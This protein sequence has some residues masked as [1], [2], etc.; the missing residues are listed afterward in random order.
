MTKPITLLLALLVAAVAAMGQVPVITSVSPSSGSVGSSVTIS[1]SNFNSSVSGNVVS[2]GG[3]HAAVTSAGTSQLV[4]TVPNGA[5]YA[6]VSVTN[7]ATR[8]TAY[9]SQPFTTTFSQGNTIGPSA[10][11][12]NVDFGTGNNP[13][14]VA[15]ADIDG[16]GK[17]DIVA[18]NATSN[19]V[20]VL[21]NNS[22]GSS[23]GSASFKGKMD[24]SVDA[25]P[26][27]IS[28]GDVDGDGR[29]DVVVAYQLGKQVSV[30]LNNSSPGAVSFLA[31]TDFSCR[32]NSSAVAIG[33]IDR[34]GKPD[35]VVA[36]FLNNNVSVLKNSTAGGGLSFAGPVDFV[37]GN[38]PGSLCISDLDG[39]GK[40]DLVVG[41]YASNT[42]S[43]LQN[44]SAN[45]T[46]D[47]STFGG[48]VDLPLGGAPT[49]LFAGD[50]DGDGKPDIVVSNYNASRN[51]VTIL[52]NN[53]S[54][55]G[56]LGSTSFASGVDFTTGNQPV[57]VGMADLDGDGKVDMVT[58]DYNSNSVTVL[59]NTSS[60]SISVSS[61]VSKTDFT[62]GNTPYGLAVGDLDGDS[63]P[64]IVSVNDAAGTLSVLHNYN[65]SAVPG[66]V[67][68]ESTASASVGSFINTDLMD[69]EWTQDPPPGY[70]VATDNGTTITG[71]TANAGRFVYFSTAG[72]VSPLVKVNGTLTF[73]AMGSGTIEVQLISSANMSIQARQT[74]T[75]TPGVFKDFGWKITGLYP[76]MEYIFAVVFNGGNSSANASGQFKKNM[77]LTLQQE[78]MSGYFTR[79]R[80]DAGSLIGNQE[81]AWYGWNYNYN[82]AR[83]KYLQHSAYS[84]MRFQTDATQIAIEYVRDF[85]DKP[86]INLFPITAVQTMSDFGADGQVVS[87]FD[88]INTGTKVTPGATYTIAGLTTT[89]PTYVF[90]NNGVP[91]SGPQPLPAVAGTYPAVYTVTAPPGAT[92]LGLLVLRIQNTG[93]YNDP[94]N[95]TYSSYSSC[96]IQQGAYGSPSPFGGTV[97]N[98]FVVYSGDKSTHISGPAIFINGSLYKYY[99]VEGSDQSQI[100]QYINDVLPPGSKTVEVMM[101]G[102]GTVSG[103]D[104]HVRRSGTYLRAVYFPSSTT[105]PAPA[106]T[107][108][109]G[110]A[111]FIH[112]SILSGYNISS[113]AQ[114][115]VWMMKILRDPSY[116]FKG[117]IFSE[118]YAGRLLYT[119]VSD[120][121]HTT[122][123]AQKLAA[124][125]VDKY[126]IQLGAND[127]GYLTPLHQFYA[128]YK[129]LV[130]QLHTLRPNARVYIQAI[131]PEF[132]EGP[133][134]E[135]Y[136]D[137]GVVTTGP[138]V[139]DFRDVQ[140]AIAT[141]HSYCE[142]VDFE[143]LFSPTY[144]HVAD[145]IHPTDAAN[146]LYTDGIKNKSTLLGGTLPSSPLAF[147]RPSIR[148]FIQSVPTISVIT[149]TGGQAPYSFSL[150]SGTVPAGLTFN[151]DGT[152]TGTASQSGTF[153]WTVQ[154]T[155]QAGSSLT[156]AFV[157][158]VNP[159]PAVVVA[160][161]H[162]QN[163]QVNAY[164]YKRL[165]GALGYG[166]YTYSTTGTL[167]PGLTVNTTSGILS[168]TPTATGT[169]SFTVKAV[170]HWGF[171]G[172]TAYSLVVGTTTPQPL[173]DT[174]TLT[175][176]I[177]SN[178]HLIVTGHLNDL[179]SQSLYSYV[180][181]YYTPPGGALTY[182][183][184]STMYVPQES[185]TG[186]SV[187]MGSL[188]SNPGT[189]AIQ[190]ATSG[191]T[192]TPIDNVNIGFNSTT[193]LTLTTSD[194]LTFTA[195]MSSNGHL[196]VTPYL[197]QPLSQ[198]V[199]VRIAP[200]YVQNGVSN[201]MPW[202]AI[203]IPAGTNG[204]PV[205]DCGN[206]GNLTNGPFTAQLHLN[207]ITPSSIN[208][209]QIDVPADTFVP[210]T[211][212]YT[213][214][215]SLTFALAFGNNGHLMVTPHLTMPVSQAIAATLIPYYSQGSSYNGLPWAN[216][217]MPSGAV[218]GPTADLGNM[219]N[220]VA[221][222]FFGQVNLKSAT[223]IAIEGAQIL[224]LPST[225]S[226]LTATYSSTDSLTF[227]LTFSNGHLMVTPHLATPVSQPI[228]T[229]LIPYYS[230]G[231][232]Y[233]G[234]PWA[235]ITMP[236]G[237]V[238]GPT[239]DL[240]NMGNLVAG[241]FSG[242]VN[243][244]SATPT[245]IDGTE[246]LV[247]PSTTS[248][249]TA[250][251]S[252][253]DSL[254][255]A[256]TFGSNGHLMVTPH[257][258][259][260]VSQPITTTLIPYYS[261][262]S[263]YNG[264]PWANITMPSGAVTGPT[265]DLG[266]MGNLV[267]GSFSGQVNLR[268]A[269]PT[270]IDGTEILVLPSTTS[271]LTASYSNTD[272][273]TLTSSIDANGDLVVMPHL[274][275]PLSQ[276]IAVT[277]VPYYTQSTSTYELP[278][279]RVV[280]PAGVVA[281]PP[282]DCG[283]MNNLTH[284]A[285]N[286][287]LNVKQV[288]PS[289]VD[290][291]QVLVQSDTYNNLSKP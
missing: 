166:K 129:S 213:S 144:D 225:T 8:Q 252:S 236:S 45:G 211:A 63:K 203:N 120:A 72:S 128:G 188:G 13:Y 258:A 102:E 116:G 109:P 50:I 271:S 253:T 108:Q 224:I 57:A 66:P 113:D 62:T 170:D 177:N 127:Y 112:D 229:T 192:P 149:A 195:A 3:V 154:V 153:N 121:A 169:Y 186:P 115:N 205:T 87:G 193:N 247:L 152:I 21:Q 288:S 111:L 22:S 81:T 277:V 244:R 40:A 210:L 32:G 37:T 182:L 67:Y 262:G 6:P 23:I 223:P 214:S 42:V 101:P 78:G 197:S 235:N 276:D 216:I 221:G 274:V 73:S 75:L 105:S 36:N 264:L 20:S 51:A 287:R 145:G 184:G 161:L 159:I 43:V 18:V 157:L 93:N 283:N 254:T 156:Q 119:D 104:P 273:L 5:A 289:A 272:S 48:K 132:Y 160:P 69:F 291:T 140:R 99:Q 239:A 53:S 231:S 198:N 286:T 207:S 130:E 261:Q 25:N 35:I 28:I 27:A 84:R 34:D 98:P 10:F 248:Q 16:D 242:Q 263:S 147:Y 38:A 178:N 257:L 39:D 82:A 227:A 58:A 110:S 29:P 237:A 49:G 14:A 33:D 215:D 219:G 191:V 46:I 41:N 44:Q 228:T 232:S 220:L 226:Q 208:G 270:A 151:A 7:T 17:P 136:A 222:S 163:G 243:L 281:G 146:Q 52:Q 126:W 90:Y 86:A 278:W 168:G 83:K 141:S 181:A 61:L 234:L 143:N 249:L 206:M 150:V 212:N 79:Y 275:S 30:L 217:T 19:T 164:Y 137:D 100:V 71:T 31:K 259:T 189:Y 123:F 255:F 268:S 139:N 138:T 250:T 122:A 15:I 125:Q 165:F 158:T 92:T 54:G 124:Y 167:P 56:S 60:G 176:A 68:P 204:G 64:D 76:Q 142:Y 135:T 183:G 246:I 284:G 70:T 218:T 180:A 162:L 265:A 194:Q 24:F 103:V 256:L 202:Q 4:V 59:R 266:N 118:G 267:A 251:Y 97:P 199:S 133:S 47:A 77:C 238:T 89:N 230:Q 185:E 233:N 201:G 114:N 2:F 11:D 91:I 12:G 175:A 9:S 134:P 26:S 131:G 173:S 280:I 260:P 174:F 285:F 107:V 245:A 240:G 241:S 279:A 96:M 155:D 172:S 269:T 200:F 179:Y 65:P 106:S 88:V 209:V 190:L 85:Y 117:D 196:M 1:G 148:S 187:D 171:S 290:G 94:S 55:P 282:V 95:D 80:A 74:F